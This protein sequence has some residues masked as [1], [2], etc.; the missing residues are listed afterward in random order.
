MRQQ[1]GTARQHKNTLYW[2]AVIL[3][4]GYCP[5]KQGNRAKASFKT[6]P[7]WL[8]SACLTFCTIFL[9]LLCKLGMQI[10]VVQLPVA[11]FLT[12]T[13]CTIV[14]HISSWCQK[15]LLWITRNCVANKHHQHQQ[16]RKLA[17]FDCRY[18]LIIFTAIGE[19]YDHLTFLKQILEIFFFVWNLY[20]F[21]VSVWALSR[22]LPP[23]LGHAL[24]ARWSGDSELTFS[25]QMWA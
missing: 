8:D 7:M 18:C 13:K 22:Y 24:N 10:R 14:L 2:Y 11:R 20:V 25:V 5:T 12:P 15:K 9:A 19:I 3:S 1:I 6:F 23:E 16:K 17:D 21:S 4:S